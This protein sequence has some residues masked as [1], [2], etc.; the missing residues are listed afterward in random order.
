MVSVFDQPSANGCFGICNGSENFKYDFMRQQNNLGNQLSADEQRRKKEIDDLLSEAMNQLTFQERQRQQEVLHGVQDAVSEEPTFIDASLQELDDQ[1][2][3]I[4]KGSAYETA[5]I[6]DPAYVS[7]TELRTLFLRCN[8]YDARE[9]ASQMLQFFE[10]KQRL[11]G[12]QK[13]VQEITVNDLS[14]DDIE[15]LNWIRLIGK[16]TAGRYGSML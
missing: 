5:E 7:N 8:E 9:T 4:K 6:L 16:D 13:L 12:L 3:L 11:F 10:V 1:L 14:E 2:M 15:A